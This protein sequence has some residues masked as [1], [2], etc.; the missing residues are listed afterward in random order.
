MEGKLRA[1]FFSLLCNICDQYLH[2]VIVIISFDTTYYVLWCNFMT[3]KMILLMCSCATAPKQW[4]PKHSKQWDFPVTLVAFSTSVTLYAFLQAPLYSPR[5]FQIS[6]C[7]LYW[8][9]GHANSMQR[10]G[11]HAWN[12]A[13]P[14][15]SILG[16]HKAIFIHSD[17]PIPPHCQEPRMIVFWNRIHLVDGY[18]QHT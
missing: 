5:R 13:E 4:T 7:N 8:F 15:L 17:L 14:L 6:N 16:G 10:R 18:S 11:P 3:W 12:C 2:C 1:Y 9:M